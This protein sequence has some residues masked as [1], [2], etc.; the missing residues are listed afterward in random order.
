MNTL[1]AFPERGGG[2]GEP[3]HNLPDGGPAAAPTSLALAHP[4]SASPALAPST[5]LP[6]SHTL[7]HQPILPAPPYTPTLAMTTL[8]PT[9][10]APPTRL[11]TPRHYKHTLA[12]L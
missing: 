11:P 10:C 12:V 9:Q 6:L 4:A 2:G 5:S 1:S 7:T 3:A 8:P